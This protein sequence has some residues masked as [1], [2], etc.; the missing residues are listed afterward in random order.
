MRLLTASDP[1]DEA[2]FIAKEINRL[3]GGMDMLE[4]GMGGSRRP[5][6]PMDAVGFSDIAV[7]Y[8]THRQAELIEQCLRQ[9]VDP[10]CGGRTGGLSRGGT[11]PRCAGFFPLF[12]SSGGFRLAPY[13]AA[14]RGRPANGG[15]PGSVCRGKEAGG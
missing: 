9:G 14:R 10:L 1:F 5:V 7:L 3:V 6:R 13:P 4:A 15:G 12:D 8:R 11:G 2:L